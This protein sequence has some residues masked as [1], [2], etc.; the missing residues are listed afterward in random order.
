MCAVLDCCPQRLRPTGQ[1]SLS[2]QLL[3]AGGGL[4]DFG[5]SLC[6]LSTVGGIAFS[7]HNSKAVDTI[8]CFVK[9]TGFG[10][11]WSS[12]AHVPLTAVELFKQVLHSTREKALGYPIHMPQILSRLCSGKT[13]ASQAWRLVHVNVCYTVSSEGPATTDTWCMLHGWKLVKREYTWKK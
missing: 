10:G 3:G 2:S 1:V 7:P 13:K 12:A 8:L 11:L 9:H 5:R 6:L 4:Y